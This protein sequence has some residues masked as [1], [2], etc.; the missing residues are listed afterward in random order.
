MPMLLGNLK[1]GRAVPADPTDEFWHAATLWILGALIAV[2]VALSGWQ[3]G[4]Q[5]LHWDW[6]LISGLIVFFGGAIAAHALPGRLERLVRTLAA[7]DVI[8]GKPD[9]V[10]QLL[11]D[12][13]AERRHWKQ[14][15]GLGAALASA[16]AFVAT[17]L[18]AGAPSLVALGI[19][20]TIIAYPAGRYLGAMAHVGFLHRQL[21]RYGL[22]AVARPGLADQTGGLRAIGDLYFVQATVVSLP[23]AYL[24]SWLL[25]IVLSGFFDARYGYWAPAYSGL[26]AIALVFVI[27]AFFLPLWSFHR[28]MASQKARYVEQSLAAR[29]RMHQLRDALMASENLEEEQRL[30]REIDLLARKLR[31]IEALPTW[32]IAPSTRRRFT[33]NNTVLACPLLVQLFSEIGIGASWLTWLRSHLGS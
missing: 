19:V 30:M 4:G 5:F 10:E 23:A 15:A 16:L 14:V 24:A 28:D 25:L 17:T 31:E 13:R 33:L 9:A 3:Y 6:M 29:G 12:L 7:A 1:S 20:E 26:L 27:L 21:D 32:P 2:A 18:Q 8:V 11:V 22:R